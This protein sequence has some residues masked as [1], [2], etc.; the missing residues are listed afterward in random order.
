MQRPIPFGISFDAN[1]H[2]VTIIEYMAIV[3]LQALP[4]FSLHALKCLEEI[5]RSRIKMIEA[6][7]FQNVVTHASPF[8]RT[9]VIRGQP[10]SR[11][12]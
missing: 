5:R 7:V 6:Q 8:A 11:R 3:A 12:V 2:V 4:S 1:I 10:I 9:L